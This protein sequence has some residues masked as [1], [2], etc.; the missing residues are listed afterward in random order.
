MKESK[1][2]GNNLNNK[3]NDLLE[4]LKDKN[5]LPSFYEVKEFLTINKTNTLEIEEGQKNF[6]MVREVFQHLLK[7]GQKNT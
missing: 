3:P 5:F 6:F 4:K 7:F 1:K 2:L